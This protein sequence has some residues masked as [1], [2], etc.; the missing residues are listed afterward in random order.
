MR[1]SDPNLND[2]QRLKHFDYRQDWLRDF[3]TQ[4]VKK[5]NA[6]VKQW[7]ELGIVVAH[8]LPSGSENKWLPAQFW[9]ES[10]RKDFKQDDATFKQVEQAEDAT[11]KAK[12]K[13][14]L[15]LDEVAG[16][17]DIAERPKRERKT[18]RRDEM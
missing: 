3:G 15:L 4:Y 17:P 12:A 8:P 1:L 14:L 6:M 10:D 7:H 2:A 11:K 18:F 13:T 9:V 16:R 5:I